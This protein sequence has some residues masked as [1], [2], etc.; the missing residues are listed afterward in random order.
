V[1]LV[2]ALK[3]SAI[4]LSLGRVAP[5]QHALLLEQRQQP[6]RLF[7]DEV[8]D[9][10]VVEEVDARP[11]EPLL[12][13]LLLLKGEDVRIELLLQALVRVVDAELLE[14]VCREDLD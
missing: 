14:R 6:R 1:S 5:L 7:A 4:R 10:L 11:I 8:D 2:E 9:F 12:C 3:Q 13:V